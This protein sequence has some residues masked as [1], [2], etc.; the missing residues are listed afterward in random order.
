MGLDYKRRALRLLEELLFLPSSKAF[1]TLRLFAINKALTFFEYSS[2]RRPIM[3]RFSLGWRAFAA[4]AALSLSSRG[5]LAEAATDSNSTLPPPEM[6][7]TGQET[8]VVGG[9]YRPAP[10]GDANKA[11]VVVLVMHAQSDYL[12]C[13]LLFPPKSSDES[14]PAPNAS[15]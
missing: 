10:G 6:I 12:T 8:G 11:S 2:P 3:V 7:S 4:L 1:R 14:W 15:S 5:F 9:L 13:E